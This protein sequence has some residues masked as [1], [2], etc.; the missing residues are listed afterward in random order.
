MI[1]SHVQFCSPF[2]FYFLQV[3]PI[4]VNKIYP[5]FMLKNNENWLTYSLSGLHRLICFAY[6]LQESESISKETLET[7]KSVFLQLCSKCTC[8]L[9]IIIIIELYLCSWPESGDKQSL[10]ILWEHVKTKNSISPVTENRLQNK[11]F[12][13]YCCLGFMWMVKKEHLPNYFW[14]HMIMGLLLD[15]IEYFP[16]ININGRLRKLC[17]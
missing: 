9:C 4:Y 2:R 1:I 8:E 3:S 10:C 16:W 13:V 11:L 15:A 7:K 14:F 12:M 17:L 5:R 6:Y